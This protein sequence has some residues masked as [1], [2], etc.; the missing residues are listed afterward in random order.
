MEI[1]EG[2]A[3]PLWE[4]SEK[5]GIP[6]ILGHVSI[7]LYN[8]RRLDMEASICMENLSTLN[9]FF[10]GRD[11]SW[12]YLITVE[13]EARGAAAIVPLMLAID[14]I[15][16]H[17]ESILNDRTGSTVLREED[18]DSEQD[19][20][21]ANDSWFQSEVDSASHSS[22]RRFDISHSG[23]HDHEKICMNASLIG[24]LDGKR[25]AIYVTAQ[26]SKIAKAIAKMTDSLATM[27]E[28]CHP[29]IFYHRVRPFLSG[30]KHNPTLPDGVV[31]KGVSDVP[32][33]YYG[34][35]AA[36]S[37]LIPMLDI[38]L[39]ISHDSI[40]SQEFLEAMRLYMTKPHRKFLEYLE[41]VACIR[42]F[43]VE[44]LNEH[45]NGDSIDVF[46]CI[47]LR[48]AYDDAVRGLQVWHKVFL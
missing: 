24:N 9:N 26:L 41:S 6:P 16:R 20:C 14:A 1:P 46:N 15:Q 8:W 42:K 10:D 37:A 7:V 47:E 31:Y 38:G 23:N 4:I 29:F 45:E 2:I 12:F 33:Q 28:G 36:Q 18:T 25:V 3:V 32:K 27:R 19:S 30:W 13:I 21:D 34:G 43:V 22:G 11:E 17:N 48:N 5:L 40:K 44:Y 35:S 39:G